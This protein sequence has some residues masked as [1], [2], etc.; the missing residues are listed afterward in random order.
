M[1]NLVIL[2]VMMCEDSQKVSVKLNI[3]SS[4]F[5]SRGPCCPETVEV[6]QVTQ[7]MTNVSWSPATGARS[8]LTSLSSRRGDAKCHTVDT[9]C[10]MGCITCST[11]Y[12]I[13][14]EAI[15]STGHVSQCTY[16]GFSSSE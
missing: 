2:I 1:C 5:L 7:A 8:F 15:S 12:S 16:H 4:I 11:N 9:H 10:L 3:Y 14:M 6:T 13:N